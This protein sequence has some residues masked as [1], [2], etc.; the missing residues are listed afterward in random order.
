[1]ISIEARLQNLEDRESI[2]EAVAAYSLRI[3]NHEFASIPD[4]FCEDG[5]FHIAAANLNIEGREKLNA[6]FGMMRPG[7]AFPFVQSSAITV[8]G[9]EA[10]HVGVMQN[11][12]HT[13]DAPCY[14]G[15]Y[16][17]RLRRVE[18][19]WLFAERRFHFVLNDP[20]AP[21]D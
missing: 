11:V 2:R 18:G 17:D 8:D 12:P 1:M 5:L 21:K 9:D 3:L 7:V 6:F 16:N 19:R 15:I 14:L 4:L 13:S 20:Y 10:T